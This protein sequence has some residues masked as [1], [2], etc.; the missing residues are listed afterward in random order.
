M[1]LKKNEYLVSKAQK[2]QKAKALNSEAIPAGKVLQFVAIIENADD[3]DGTPNASIRFTVGGVLRNV[4][5]RQYLQ[6]VGKNGESMMNNEEGESIS[7]P[8]EITIVSATNRKNPEG[9]NVWPLTL[10]KA[11]SEMFGKGGRD[12]DYETLIAEGFKAGVQAKIDAGDIDAVKD[13]VV[14]F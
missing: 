3:E 13:Y 8:A 14:E 11:T 2:L 1:S 10:Y 9:E 5:M 12:F 7:I 6:F 4:S